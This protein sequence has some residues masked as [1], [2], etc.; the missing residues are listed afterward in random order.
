M[1]AKEIMNLLEGDDNQPT[2]EQAKQSLEWPKWE[3]AIQAKLA[4]L[5]QKGT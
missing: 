1:S 2:L 4:Q 3:Y 5:Q